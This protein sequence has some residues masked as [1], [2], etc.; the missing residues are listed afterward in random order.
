MPDAGQDEYDPPSPTL[1]GCRKQESPAEHAGKEAD[2][3]AERV[4]QQIVKGGDRIQDATKG[5]NQAQCD[6]DCAALFKA[7]CLIGSPVA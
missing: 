5:G 6:R 4:R 7:P 2:K 3:A 1:W